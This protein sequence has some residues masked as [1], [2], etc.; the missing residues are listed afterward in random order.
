MIYDP[1]GKLVVYKA[2]MPDNPTLKETIDSL[3]AK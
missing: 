1:E 3:L 2:A